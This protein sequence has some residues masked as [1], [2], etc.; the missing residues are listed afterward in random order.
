MIKFMIDFIKYFYLFFISIEVYYYCY[1]PRI[2]S[3]FNNYSYFI[4]IFITNLYIF[5]INLDFSYSSI[6]IFVEIMLFIFDSL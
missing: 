5:F 1:L 2:F 3:I 4:D 6:I